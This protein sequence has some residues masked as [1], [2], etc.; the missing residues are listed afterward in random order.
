[1]DVTALAECVLIYTEYCIINTLNYLYSFYCFGMFIDA[2][3][4][5]FWHSLPVVF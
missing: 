1:M 5:S 3:R 4:V 2:L